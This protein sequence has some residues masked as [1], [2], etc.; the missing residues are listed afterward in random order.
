V[1]E[2]REA[3]NILSNEEKEKSIKDYVVRETAVARKRVNDA[4]TAIKQEHEEMRSVEC[5]G[6]RSRDI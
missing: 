1:A 5:G 4:E 2:K 3:T 6:L